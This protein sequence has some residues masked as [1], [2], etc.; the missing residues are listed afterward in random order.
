MKVKIFTGAD[1]EKLE[2]D[3]NGWIEKLSGK[4]G[5]KWT[6]TAAAQSVHMGNPT[7]PVFVITIWYDVG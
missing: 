4:L 3:V 7:P 2:A 5:I 1:P 6:Q